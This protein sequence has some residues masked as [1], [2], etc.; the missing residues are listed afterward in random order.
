[1]QNVV[2]KIPRGPTRACVT[3]T[4]NT[5]QALVDWT[6]QGWHPLETVSELGRWE[7]M[8]RPWSTWLSGPRCLTSFG[9][10]WRRVGF[11]AFGLGIGLS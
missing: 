5:E 7:R 2:I 1:M 3:G 8:P 6:R 10:D 9:I 4:A 11:C